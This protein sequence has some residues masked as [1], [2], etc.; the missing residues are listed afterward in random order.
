VRSEFAGTSRF[1]VARRLGQGAF[2]VVYE[3][4]DCEREAVVALK[5]LHRSDPEGLYRFKQEFR[6]L[7]DLVHPNLVSLYELSS[8]GVHWFFTMELVSGAPFLDHLRGGQA[9]VGLRDDPTQPAAAPS[10]LTSGDAGDD[11]APPVAEVTPFLPPL[12]DVAA[13]RRAFRQL[14]E[15][16]LFLHERGKLHRD[17]KPSNVL[18]TG[19]GRVVIL[20]FGLVTDRGGPGLAGEAVVG[21]PS[22]MAPEQA[23][24][25]PVA[26]AADWYAVGVMLFEALAGR[27]PFAGGEREVL[28][29]KQVEDA[30]S[31]S[32]F[33]PGIPSDL[34]DLCRDLLQR[35]PARRPRGPDVL[36]RLAGPGGRR[37][38]APAAPTPGTR[39]VGRAAELAALHEARTAHRAGPAAVAI[40]GGSGLGKSAL[41]RRFL[42]EAVES[43]PDTVVLAGR[44]YPTESVP[45][46]ALDSLVDALRQRLRLLAPAEAEGLSTLDLG[47]LARLFPVLRGVEGV[48][49]TAPADIPDP[50]ELRRR[51]TLAFRQLLAWLADRHPVIL[52][53]DD[54]QWGDADS[55]NLM[56]EVLRGPDAPAV[57]LLLVYREGEEAT[58]AFLRLLLPALPEL[59]GYGLVTVGEMDV[60]EAE[61]LARAALGDGADEGRAREIVREGAGNPFLIDELARFRREESDPVGLDHLIRFRVEALPAGAR[62]LLELVAVAGQPLAREVLSQAASLPGEDYAALNLLRTSRLVRPRD[63]EGADEIEAYHDRIRETVAAQIPPADLRAHH[64]RLGAVLEASRRADPETLAVHFGQGGEVQKASRYAVAAAAQAFDA[65]AFERAARLYRQALD[66]HPPAAVEERALRVRLGDALANA[67]RGAQAAEAYLAAARGAGPGEAVDLERRAADQLLR[68][69][70]HDEGLAVLRAVLA[71][72]HLKLPGSPLRALASLIVRRARLAWRGL[73]FQERREAEVAAADLLRIDTCWSVATTLSLIDIVCAQEFQARHLFLALQSGE[74]RRVARALIYEVPFVATAGSGTRPRTEAL[75][76]VARPL[77]ERLQ[78]PYLDGLMALTRGSSAH[79]QGRFAEAREAC[80]RADVILRERCTGVAW[81]LDTNETFWLTCLMQLG[82]LKELSSRAFLLLEEA[83]R[84][85]DLYAQSQALVRHIHV[86]RLADDQPA[87]AEAALQQGGEV[88]PAR[89][90]HLQHFWGLMG[91]VETDLYRGAAGQAWARLA[92]GWRDFRRSLLLRVEILR[93]RALHLRGRT[94]LAAAL[95][96]VR[97]RGLLA[98]ASREAGRLSR[99]P[100]PWAAPH[101]HAI[102]AGLA[103]VRGRM[104]DAVRELD[105]AEAG[106]RAAGMGLLAAACRRQRGQLVGGEDGRGLATSADVWM[107]GQGI[108]NPARL[109]AML[110]P[111]R[112]TA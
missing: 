10:T 43:Q 7:A 22:Y 32:T 107:A 98:T 82:E 47:S 56:L 55:A 48:G 74:P 75:F 64:R 4:Y 67:G 58:S 54:G 80:A 37:A 112:W 52:S 72:Q 62:R 97:E 49:A 15:G 105:T 90:F 109:C 33:R 61:L 99:E 78:D 96:G 92:T 19:E 101:A 103:S 50:Q 63:T 3:A 29:R 44:C 106:F 38:A 8:E 14:A 21:T 95:E 84:R 94:A 45:Y 35:D 60:R 65:L 81:E 1:R 66:L 9:A 76:A 28:K 26:E 31:P 17:I 102:F 86:A 34:D 87:E 25:H 12:P 39:F 5:T 91:R 88:W 23:A 77:A 100:A 27:R 46:K 36:R 40:K 11:Q 83:R 20:D 42:A 68:A 6:S 51:A 69:G 71:R 93:V 89:G 57:L 111:G 16:L 110:V 73:E 13:L 30:L 79:L 41:V 53:I 70:H 104:E 108:R 24:G 2:G 59:R 85:G 18:V